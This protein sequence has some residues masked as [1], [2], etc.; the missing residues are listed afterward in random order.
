MTIY[1]VIFTKHRQYAILLSMNS[2]TQQ[3]NDQKELQPILQGIGFSKNEALVYLS[4]LELGPSSIWD[5]AKKSGLKRST[6]YSLLEELALKGHA[7]S[8]NDGKRVLYAVTS[9]KRLMLAAKTRY[10]RFETA[11]S[12]LDALASKSTQKPVVRFY[13]GLA[14]VREV[15]LSCLDVPKGT[16]ILYMGSDEII[17]ANYP[18]LLKEYMALRQERQVPIRVL[19]EDTPAN[20]EIGPDDI[21]Q[22]RATR[23][24]PSE[25]F[26][27]PIETQISG[28]RVAYISHSTLMPFAYVIE[29]AAFA[30]QE[31]QKFEVMWGAAGG[32]F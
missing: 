20:R 26:H 22:L 12:R 30:E 19:F 17:Q 28:D 6:C 4:V 3:T 27:P 25:L 8:S 2:T 14:G 7:S 18:E 15:Y 5:I 10:S 32:G 1:Q 24:L 29:N 9:P 11:I 13:E 21:N 23:Y 31:R 16:E